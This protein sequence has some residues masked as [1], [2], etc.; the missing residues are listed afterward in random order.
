MIVEVRVGNICVHG[1][2]SE[3]LGPGNTAVPS[4]IRVSV[5]NIVVPQTHFSKPIGK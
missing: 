2:H 3:V 1:S 5:A 4:A